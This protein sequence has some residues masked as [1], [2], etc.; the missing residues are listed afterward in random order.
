MINGK[1]Y[2]WEDLSVMLPHGLAL[3]IIDIEYDWD[4]DFKEVYGKGSNPRGY[5]AGNSKYSCKITVLREEFERMLADARSRGFASLAAIRPFEII[6][7]Y[8]NEDE[9]IVTDVIHQAKLKKVGTKQSQGS[10]KT[11][12]EVE[13]LVLG[14][15]TWNRMPSA[16]D[17]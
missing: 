3:D 6:C 13:L 15:I 4:P 1:R 9:P 7:S 2:A 14:G 5:G 10:E 16:L 12:V 8:A 17:A 11:E